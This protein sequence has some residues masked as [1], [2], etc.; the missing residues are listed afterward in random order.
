MPVATGAGKVESYSGDYKAVGKRGEAVVLNW[1]RGRPNVA[2]VVDLRTDW[3]WREVDVDARI[4]WDSGKE[5][6]AEIKTD[7][8]ARIG[9]N[10]LIEILRLNHRTDALGRAAE[11]GWSL[12]SPASWLFVYCPA[13]NCILY[14]RMGRL[15][16]WFQTWSYGHLDTMKQKW[17]RTDCHKSTLI[18]LVP[19]AECGHLLSV[20][21]LSENS[22]SVGQKPIDCY[23]DI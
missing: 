13:P 23:Q 6:L 5:D 7:N 14:A 17:I 8:H 2:E 20:V 18:V 22:S 15:R 12:R 10:V 16:E 19:W 11:T 9:G 4:L 21:K 1:L 3:H